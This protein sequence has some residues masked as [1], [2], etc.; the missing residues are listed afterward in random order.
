MITIEEQTLANGEKRFRPRWREGGARGGRRMVESFAD[1]PTAQRFA[2]MVEAHGK[3]MPPE[4]QLRAAGF[5]AIA[6]KHFPPVPVPTVLTVADW[7]R[8]YIATLGAPNT[9]ESVIAGY[10]DYLRLQVEPTDL[11]KMPVTRATPT[12][13]D[14]K[15]WR[16]SAVAAGAKNGGPLSGNTVGRIMRGLL[17]PALEMAA[18]EGRRLGPDS[19]L[20]MDNPMAIVALPETEMPRRLRLHTDQDM[21]IVYD[22]A[23]Q[24]HPVFG[25]MVLTM[26]SF[27]PRWGEV[28]GLTRSAFDWQAPAGPTITVHTVVDKHTGKLRPKP[29]TKAGYRTWIIPDNLQPM[30]RARYDAA[31]GN[32][33][34][35]L[36]TNGAGRHWDYSDWRRDWWL[37]MLEVARAMGLS[38]PID[39]QGLRRTNITQLHLKNVPDHALMVASGHSAFRLTVE[40]YVDTDN[41]GRLMVAEAAGDL[42]GRIVRPR[43][44]P[45]A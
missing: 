35:V 9:S 22:A 42:V 26:L 5:D 24:V 1:R 10:R 32:V 7:C 14:C 30:L 8:K 25:E 28:A 31:E 12:E 15:I 21:A 6:D 27:G 4:A 18:R 20:P 19:D 40:T 45:A 34:G 41:A 39:A 29:K 33:A 43:A 11:G 44:A 36:F 17:R 23:A 38:R 16:N 2:Y 3:R 37:P 13:A